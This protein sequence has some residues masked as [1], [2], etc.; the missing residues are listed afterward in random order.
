MQRC[1]Y[2]LL[3][4]IS[5]FLSCA[6]AFAPPTV[7]IMRNECASRHQQRR[8]PT[9]T[10][11][12]A[13]AID[14]SFMW[15]RGLSF[16]KG[17]FKFYNGFDDWMKPFPDA[18]RQEYPEI[19]QLPTGLYEVAL[20]KPLGIVFEEISAGRG[21]FVKELVEGGNAARTAKVQVGDV[22]VGITAVKIVGAKYER[23]MIPSRTFDF[24]TMVGA[25]GSNDPKFQCNNVIL[26]LER[27]S[28][29]D[30]KRVDE[31][32]DFFEPPFDCAWKQRQ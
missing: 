32:L 18:D 31:W 10:Q 2:L 14:T 12:F 20:S 6:T 30:S 5:L 16:G 7:S 29:A 27:P 1:S 4:S 21:L 22:L 3:L 8:Q 28:E 25:V 19:F 13:T 17:N 11:R 15:N 26:M 23:R 9:T 24:D